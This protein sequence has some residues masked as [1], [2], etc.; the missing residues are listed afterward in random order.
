MKSLSF[1]LPVSDNFKLDIKDLDTT[2]TLNFFIG[3]NGSGKSCLLRELC[4]R[5]SSGRLIYMPAEFEVN[6]ELSVWECLEIFDQTEVPKAFDLEHLSVKS[7]LKNLSSG[8][9]QRLLLALLL[10]HPNCDTLLL[11]EPTNFLDP[12]YKL[13]LMEALLNSPKQLYI[14]SHDLHWFVNATNCQ[15]F[16]LNDGKISSRG[17]CLEVLRSEEISAAFGLNFHLTNSQ[18]ANKERWGIFY[19]KVGFRR[20]EQS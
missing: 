14:A 19:E 3:P 11:D 8:T 18:I 7:S 5:L 9:K 12:K 15:L 6:P 16:L 4:N 1:S 20:E 10:N 13:E 17:N 2:Q